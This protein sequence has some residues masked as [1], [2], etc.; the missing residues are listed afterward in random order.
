M[1][2][3]LLH[4]CFQAQACR[5]VA[6]LPWSRPI[7]AHVAR[8]PSYSEREL[9]APRPS[10]VAVDPKHFWVVLW[11]ASAAV[12]V[13]GLRPVAPCRAQLPR[14]KQRPAALPCDVFCFIIRAACDVIF[15]V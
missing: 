15:M 1:E 6:C 5:G 7:R 9:S 4:V 2:V 12:G 13:L 11:W 14:N 10:P 8:F 3:G